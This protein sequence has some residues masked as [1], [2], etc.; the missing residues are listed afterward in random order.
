MVLLEHVLLIEYIQYGDNMHVL[1]NK[2]YI[3]A[4]GLVLPR[5]AG[6]MITAISVWEREMTDRRNS[7]DG[8]K[9]LLLY[10]D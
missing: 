7:E 10:N 1:A 5:A 4:D 9:P 2:F 3:V 6:S 8:T